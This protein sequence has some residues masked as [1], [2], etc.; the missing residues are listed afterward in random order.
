M[1]KN[2][3]MN[4]SLSHISP[5]SDQKSLNHCLTVFL[6]LAMGMVG[7]GCDDPKPPTVELSASEP[8]ALGV[9]ITILN[10]GSGEGNG[11]NWSLSA[12]PSASAA[13]LVNP[14]DQSGEEKRVLIPD[15]L[16]RYE[17]TASESLEDF[18]ATD[19]LELI[20]TCAPAEWQI[21]AEITHG[22]EGPVGQPINMI[23]SLSAVSAE[24]CPELEP[25][26]P[27]ITWAF[28]SKPNSSNANLIAVGE[29]ARTLTPDAIGSYLIGVTV[30]DSLGRRHSTELRFE[31]TCGLAT[32]IVQANAAFQEGRAQQGNWVVGRPLSLH[33]DASDTDEGCGLEQ[34][35]ELSWRFIELPPLSIAQIVP[36]TGSSPWFT[37]DV[38][39]SYLVEALATD[40]QNHTGRA[41]VRIEVSECG[42]AVPTITEVNASP[43]PSLLS[44]SQ[45]TV[46]WMDADLS[47]SCAGFAI[48][49]QHVLNWSVVR[50]PTA[51]R[52]LPLPVQALQPNFVA[53][54][55]GDYTLRVEVTDLA[56]HRDYADLS[57]SVDDCGSALPTVSLS[58]SASEVA[59][60]TPIR[61]QALADDP[62]LACGAEDEVSLAWRVLSA[63]AGAPTL[64]LPTAS[65]QAIEF[66]GIL[67]VPGTYL[68]EVTPTDRM[69]HR[70]FPAQVRIEALDCGAFA[71]SI[72]QILLGQGDLESTL[73]V[74]GSTE[75][76]LNA[77][78]NAS[79]SLSA[80]V[81]DPN[82]VCRDRLGLPPATL[83]AVDYRWR[84]E[85][86]P[87][88]SQLSLTE[89]N[90]PSLSLNFDVAGS[91]DLSLQVQHDALS[92][93]VQF[94][95]HVDTCG[96][97]YPTITWVD[98]VGGARS[99]S[100]VGEAVTLS[101]SAQDSDEAEG[102]DLVQNLRYQW[103]WRA[104]PTGSLAILNAAQSASAWFT[105][106]L[107]GQYVAEVTVDDPQDHSSTAFAS[108]QVGGCGAYRPEIS[109]ITA[110]LAEGL[111]EAQINSPI[112]FL[113]DWSDQDLNLAECATGDL[114]QFN[115]RLMTAPN[116]SQV[117]LH[118]PQSE[119]PSFIPD[120]PGIYLWELEIRDAKGLSTLSTVG[121]E[122]GTC[123]SAIPS[124]SLH[125]PTEPLAVGVNALIEAVVSDAD[126]DCT[127][128][129]KHTYQYDWR[130]TSLPVGASEPFVPADRP[131]LTWRA[132]R[133]GRY[134][135]SVTVL[136]QE[137]HVSPPA[138][139][140]IEIEACGDLNPI[141]ENLR[142][143]GG[144]TVG[145]TARLLVDVS[146]PN[147][148]CAQGSPLSYEWLLLSRPEGS[149]A[150]LDSVRTQATPSITFDQAGI[151]TARLTVRTQL[152][153]ASHQE[154][155]WEVSNCGGAHPVASIR[156]EPVTPT[157]GSLAQLM[158]SATDADSDL[159]CGETVSFSY[160][161]V[162][163]D[164][165]SGYP[166][167]QLTGSAPWIHITHAGQYR[168]KLIVE[169]EDGHL[170]EPAYLSFSVEN[171]G[172]TPPSLDFASITL[173]P[174]SPQ[175]NEIALLSANTIDSDAA[176]GGVTEA[177]VN[178]RAVQVP[179]GAT[180]EIGTG[181]QPQVLASARGEYVVEATPIG[182]DG[183]R[184]ASERFSFEVGPCG[185]F[186]PNLSISFMLEGAL[187]AINTATLGSDGPSVIARASTSDDDEV[188][189]CTL[190]QDRSVRWWVSAAPNGIAPQLS[191]ALGFAEE[192]ATE[193]AV[194][195]NP[196]A[197]GAYTLM[198][199]VRDETGRS[200]IAQATFT[201]TSCGES[202]PQLS[203]LTT[204]PTL[205]RVGEAVRFSATL[206]PADQNCEATDPMSYQWI[207]R[208]N[209][210]PTNSNV[211]LTGG[212]LAQASLV[213]D[214]AG[215]YELSV[216]V[217]SPNGIASQPLDFTLTVPDCG[218]RAPIITSAPTVN[219][220][221][222]LGATLTLAVSGQDPDQ[223]CGAQSPLREV[224]QLI[225]APVGSQANLSQSTGA[226]VGIVPDVEG[227]YIVEVSLI[228][229]EA[230]PNG[231]FLE[232]ESAQVSFI[233]G[234][235]GR[236]APQALIHAIAPIE[237]AAADQ[238]SFNTFACA[239]APFVQL[240]G[241]DSIDPNLACG[242]GGPLQYQ[243]EVLEVTPGL[244]VSLSNPNSE[245]LNLAISG[246]GEGET[247]TLKVRLTTTN[248]AGLKDYAIANINLTTLFA[249]QANNLNPSFL[250][251]QAQVMTVTG[252]HF[253]TYNQALPRML[254][255]GQ[256]I[257]ADLVGGCNPVANTNGLIERCTSI[258]LTLPGGLNADL[259]DAVIRNPY[260]LGCDDR[261]P[262]ELFVISSP[263]IDSFSP[264][265][266]C[267]GQFEGRLTL[268]GS[269]FVRDIPNAQEVSI[270]INGEAAVAPLLST[271]EV[272]SGTL[273]LCSEI[274]FE[275]PLNQKDVSELD[276]ILSNP[277]PGTCDP[278]SLTTVEPLFQ[279]EPPQ[280]DDVV[281]SKICDQGGRIN[282][283]G[284]YLEEGITVSLA[285]QLAD[286][287]TIVNGE[288][289]VSAYWNEQ[290]VPRFAPGIYDLI[291]TNPT[292]C[293]TILPDQVRITEGPVPFFV[294]PPI[295]YNGITLQATAY[296]GNLFGGAVTRVQVAQG[297]EA[298]IDLDFAFD[299]TTPGQL[300]IFIPQ[301]IPVGLY[302]LTLFD[303]VNCPGTTTGLLTIT[304][305]LTVNLT[306]LTPPFA[307]TQGITPVTAFAQQ[308]SG[309]VPTPRAYLTPSFGDECL[310]QTECNGSD[311]C[312]NGR[313]SQTCSNTT[314]CEVG[315][316]CV[317]GACVAQASE[318]RATSIRSETEIQGAIDQGFAPGFYD[319]V[320]VN[321]NGSVGLLTQ[322]M[323]VNF[324]PPPIVKAVSPGSW[325][326][327]NNALPVQIIGTGFSGASVTATCI[328]NG[329]SN[330]FAL[331][332]VSESE[333]LLNV[334]VNTN[335][336]TSSSICSIRLLNADQSYDDFSPL[337]ASPPSGNFVAFSA[338]PELPAGAERKL[339][340]VTYAELPN[341]GP[342]LF[343]MGGEN[344]VG[345]PLSDL[346][347]ARIDS[348]GA[349]GSWEALDT[350]LPYGLTATQ[351]VTLGRFIYI[352]SGAQAGGG[353]TLDVLRAELLDPLYVPEVTE[354]DFEFDPEIN[355]LQTGVYYY[356]I[357]A[358]YDGNDPNNPGGE[359]LPSEPQPV[360][361]PN[362]PNIGVRLILQW[363]GLPD[364]V[365]YRIYRSPTP[366]LLLGQEELIAQV[367]ASE[368]TFTDDGS[369]VTTPNTSTLKQGSLGNW[370]IVTQLNVA[371]DH[372]SV[373]VAPDPITENLHH[374]YAIAGNVNGTASASYEYLSVDI[375]LERGHVLSAPILVDNA[376]SAPRSRLAALTGTPQVA[377]YLAQGSDPK[378]AVIYV[379][380]G[381]GTKNVEVG[382]VSPGGQ[383]TPIRLISTTNN[384]AGY[385]AAIAN[386]IIVIVGGFNGVASFKSDKGTIC[387]IACDPTVE[388]IDNWTSLSN[389]GVRDTVDAGYSS[390]KGFFYIVAGGDGNNDVSTKVDVAL[391]GGTP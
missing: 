249:P 41:E 357:S 332:V 362:I 300:K 89:T 380:S 11:V 283:I 64:S 210:R 232:S 345:Q 162:V 163:E 266:I 344:G 100:G 328:T 278:D 116:G 175:I 350:T 272:V 123:G 323:K 93:Q 259:Y 309:F 173:T 219:G 287:V 169:D 107:P 174:T 206:T 70:G 358:V 298:P 233:A 2:K 190:T 52:A 351:A 255:G 301:N 109:A 128:Q 383:L 178:W 99:V 118:L 114:H 273:E 69:G 279:S 307:W 317:T 354:V 304:D 96:L 125:L 60:G 54:L 135:L 214:V 112:T 126:E 44:P 136:D 132:D 250:C 366:D 241:G 333:N 9:P 27:T 215:D 364:A 391:L 18:T 209:R 158:A 134:E 13:L 124:V 199:E 224:W 223:D 147:Q 35:L 78:L 143:E 119:R 346:Y 381:E 68:I 63:P 269:G 191:P 57:F 270:S 84:L 82:E 252:D 228:E 151:Y 327:N 320:V 71:P 187:D 226:Q 120:L 271:C 72:D 92:T 243:W 50:A 230:Q 258:T 292:N 288:Q 340:S 83:T 315:L 111:I 254:I 329:A 138:L 211:N 217:M 166:S 384:R 43:S 10:Q 1:L 19:R 376:F 285:G 152:G 37:P 372:H 61:I 352:L 337:T 33:A 102:C 377:S 14:D 115:W 240:F 59:L 338:G 180:L 65:T 222:H 157:I 234:S 140:V 200:S 141:L 274:S 22:N 129:T 98:P 371:R 24:G 21:S 177:F 40:P 205:A 36:T 103:H 387:G 179:A 321:P 256:Q 334:T 275:L 48:E 146:D 195:F 87:Q 153:T 386:N 319:L 29:R 343:L 154:L 15:V 165:P 133:A 251:A 66:S 6:M 325:E 316:A 76:I 155:S 348:F 46:T 312:V 28:L 290:P 16:G 38:P 289:E 247:G 201:L 81:S 260:P 39:G 186:S 185:G 194:S 189:P 236:Q 49:E 184:G 248:L 5:C 237:V 349:L 42:A 79:V 53:D 23:A 264:R 139:G 91:Y 347:T 369:L 88:G 149:L 55:P 365:S 375:N 284:Q 3:I 86:T 253:Y 12:K 293:S 26:E 202:Q 363:D 188:L 268:N 182:A 144:L 342:A 235:C 242:L 80:T 220:D 203:N 73:D 276:L 245:G 359:S 374:I 95:I 58:A 339:P 172:A 286:T 193:S 104:V 90:T 356:R 263:S 261:T 121:V 373:V 382:E 330:T 335:S 294:D 244:E 101:V 74:M 106:D 196:M 110:V 262:P 85:R 168:F 94:T 221:I 331:N 282:L 208:L 122:V 306:E 238:I 355:G 385:A 265:P 311:L 198:A 127:V 322:A 97:A 277:N 216:Q 20:V 267:R 297:Q 181:S 77:S 113:V 291:A 318:L 170:S 105:P 389:V 56:G 310:V 159:A 197:L 164:V 17:I 303:D 34:R 62:D 161:W 314:E 313:C 176:C 47:E 160:H 218:G 142:V 299:P 25:L 207:W 296:L 137:G 231:T 150:S 213:P 192:R 390:A 67:S 32:P 131:S 167:L 239:E 360:F 145:G 229:T 367:P 51:S 295:V 361:I 130:I 30:S 4:N 341:G 281:P 171:C 156:L 31:A 117:N 324:D 108:I 225:S 378:S 280:I 45:L 204:S 308:G 183:L 353:N 148:A 75:M 257:T 326:I 8:W 379:L 227:Q 302:D 336:L 388:D 212:N 370:A 7:M 246:I 368:L 305:Q